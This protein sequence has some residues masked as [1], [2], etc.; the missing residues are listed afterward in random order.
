M[1]F[2]PE[3]QVPDAPLPDATPR[4]RHNRPSEDNRYQPQNRFP[5]QLQGGY[6]EN[7]VSAE[8][9]H[10]PILP[11]YPDSGCTTSGNRS[12]LLSASCDHPA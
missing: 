6:P 8:N 9:L 3:G 1:V 7:L 11:A 4:S 12:S 10:Q 5:S 2:S